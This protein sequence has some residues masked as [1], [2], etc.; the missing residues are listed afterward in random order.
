MWLADSQSA[1]EVAKSLL[2][3]VGKRYD[4]WAFVVMGNHVH[5]L[6]TPFI[7][8]PVI[9]QGIKGYTAHQINQLQNARGR[10]VWQDE[11][12]DHWARDEEE[13]SR[14]IHY[15]ENNPTAAGLC[16]TANEWQWSSAFIRDRFDWQFNAPFPEEHRDEAITFLESSQRTSAFLG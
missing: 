8:L 2:W 10:V 11:S 7:E 5:C 6:I 1:C 16:E 3:G 9:T 15:I 14:I 4:L 12:Y 13:V